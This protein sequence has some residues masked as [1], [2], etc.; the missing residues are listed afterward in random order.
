MLQPWLVRD[1]VQVRGIH[2]SDPRA[3]GFDRA[4]DPVDYLT[5]VGAGEIDPGRYGAYKAT[6]AIFRNWVGADTE[7]AAITAAKLEGFHAWLL[8]QV[9]TRKQWLRGGGRQGTRGAPGYSTDYAAS[10][11][12][13]TKMLL[14]RFADHGLASHSPGVLRTTRRRRSC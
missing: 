7:V 14:A 13:T 5:A 12:H 9:A 3:R 1:T 6:A 11:L 8:S 10:V 4:P 2:V